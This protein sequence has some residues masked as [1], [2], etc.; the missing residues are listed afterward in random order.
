M[1]K[2]RFIKDNIYSFLLSFDDKTVAKILGD[3]ELLEE[4]GCLLRPP[5]SKKTAKNLYELRVLGNISIRIFYTFYKNEIF[6]L[7]AFIKKS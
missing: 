1:S 4:L 7:D 5:K 3:L 2:I 6:I